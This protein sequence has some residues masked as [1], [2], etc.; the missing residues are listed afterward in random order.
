MQDLRDQS[1]AK[2]QYTQAQRQSV[3]P[4]VEL[5]ALFSSSDVLFALT[6]SVITLCIWLI[7][8]TYFGLKCFEKLTASLFSPSQPRRKTSQDSP[9]LPCCLKSRWRVRSFQKDIII[10]ENNTHKMSFEKVLVGEIWMMGFCKE[11]TILLLAK[12]QDLKLIYNAGP[13]FWS[14]SLTNV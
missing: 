13:S 11:L 8:I 9:S 5:S 2:W 14:Q 3:W 6:F 10:Q 4:L 12:K 7:L 1:F